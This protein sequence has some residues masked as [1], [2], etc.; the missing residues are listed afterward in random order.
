M[1]EGEPRK[2][3]YLCRGLPGSGKST[4]A[5]QLAPDTNFSAD[6][7]FEQSGKY[8]YDASKIHAAHGWCRDQVTAAMS[9]NEPVV[10]VA[11]TFT[12]S[13]EMTVYVEMAKYFGYSVFVVTCE[14]DYGNIHNC[15]PEA[16]GRMK[17][18]WEPY[19]PQKDES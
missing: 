13:W 1:S 4:L 16:I 6:M 12:Q 19:R 7:F 17:A 14:N 15:P 18:R 5:S 9:R 11:N 3:L 10:A 2:V 8:L